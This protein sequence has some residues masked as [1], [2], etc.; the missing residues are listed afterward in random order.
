MDVLG[1]NVCKYAI[2]GVSGLCSPGLK[3]AQHGSEKTLQQILQFEGI[4][5]HHDIPCKVSPQLS[6]PWPSFGMVDCFTSHP[7]H[8]HALSQAPSPGQS[9]A[10]DSVGSPER[11]SARRWPCPAWA[12][13][14]GFGQT[15]RK[16]E[17]AGRPT[18]G[19]TPQLNGYPRTGVHPTL[20]IILL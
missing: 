12:G 19:Y 4:T 18:G 15:K 16:E 9:R 5:H 20:Y 17:A 2:D 6:L 10:P 3:E 13:H 8:G 11:G 1:V 7:A 14:T